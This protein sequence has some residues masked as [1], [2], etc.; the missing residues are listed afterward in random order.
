MNK[1]KITTSILCMF[2]VWGNMLNAQIGQLRSCE[3]IKYF[4]TTTTLIVLDDES[5]SAYNKAIRHTI[6]NYWRLTPVKFIPESE[7]KNYFGNDQ[8]SMLVRNSAQRVHRRAGG[9]TS[10]IKHNDLALY[11]CDQGPLE[12]YLGGDAIAMVK[13]DDVMRV[14]DYLYELTGLVQNMQ[15]YVDF[16]ENEKIDKNNYERE[17]LRYAVER[18]GDLANF[19]LLICA[20][21]LTASM[22]NPEKLAKTYKYPVEIVSKEK[23]AEAIAAQKGDVAFMHLHPRQREFF[24]I[25]AAGGR[26]LYHAK[27]NDYG[28]LKMKDFSI[29]SK[30]IA[31]AEKE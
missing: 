12:N 18:V 8:F 24:I 20:D 30:R 17:I 3:K 10:T 26:L 16:I 9:R 14:D 15:V 22:N 4:K 1:L 25:H 7:L 31:K 2:I 27:V 29:L 28:E 23:I 13:L 11:I 19:N 6:D 5:N 21:D